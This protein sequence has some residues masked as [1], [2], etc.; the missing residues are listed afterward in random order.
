MPESDARSVSLAVESR[1]DKWKIAWKWSRESIHEKG[2]T[3]NHVCFETEFHKRVCPKFDPTNE[4]WKKT[5]KGLIHFDHYDS[6]AVPLLYVDL[7]T[8]YLFIYLLSSF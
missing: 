7:L 4:L 1:S 2:V 3:C 8:C 5:R 6:R